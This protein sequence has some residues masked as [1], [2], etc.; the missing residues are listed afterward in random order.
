MRCELTLGDGRRPRRAGL[1][2]TA[3]RLLNAIRGVRRRAPA[4]SP[5]DLPLVAGRH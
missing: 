1:F 3:M 5:L 4:C 2:A